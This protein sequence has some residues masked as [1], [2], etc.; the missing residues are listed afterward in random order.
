MIYHQ[1]HLSENIATLKWPY[2]TLNEELALKKAGIDQ[3]QS[4]IQQISERRDFLTEFR[5]WR[6]PGVPIEIER[7]E[8]AGTR[9]ALRTRI[10]PA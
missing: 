4:I 9:R 1:N 2:G 8:K 5:I 7:F 6:M 10:T 3:N